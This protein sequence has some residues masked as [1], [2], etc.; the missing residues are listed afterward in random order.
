MTGKV[1]IGVTV[2]VSSSAK[3]DI[4]VM[5]PR[6]GLPLI[7][8]EQEPHLPALQFQRTARS[9]ACVACSRWSTSRTTSPSLTSTW[10]SSSA[11][12]VASPRHT[13]KLCSAISFPSSGGLQG[14]TKRESAQLGQLFGGQVLLQLGDIEQFEQLAR[15]RRDR[16]LG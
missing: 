1:R 11:P 10:K 9:G 16:L 4:R 2:M 8:M 6:R 14:A 12:P 15:H 13:R 3:V 5:Q 7:S